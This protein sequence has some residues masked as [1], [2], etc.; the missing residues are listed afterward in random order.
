MKTI[1]IATL[2]GVSL[3]AFATADTLVMLNPTSGDLTGAPGDSV[4]WGF[5]IQNTSSGLWVSFTQSFLLNETNPS[6]G[7]YTDLIGPQGGPVNF[8]LGPNT[9]W[10][11][12]FDAAAQ[13]GVGSFL[14]D[15]AA[16]IGSVDSGSIRILWDE[17]TGDPQTC[18]DCRATEFSVDLP[19]S[20][21]VDPVP[22][23]STIWLALAGG[24]LVGVRR[25][26]RR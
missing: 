18:S 2:V 1:L 14:I 16:V 10:D 21:T 23:P 6:V 12:A 13:S 19:F 26:R 9:S 11:E 17:Y 3:T 24:L 4:G 15:P 22:E 25:M 20:V 7:M 8:E 5:D